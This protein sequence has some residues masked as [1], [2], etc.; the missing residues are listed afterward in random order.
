[1]TF[2]GSLDV[3]DALAAYFPYAFPMYF[4][5][6]VIAK[7]LRVAFA[8][9]DKPLVSERLQFCHNIFLA[10]QSFLLMGVIALLYPDTAQN[11]GE[12][13]LYNA[14][15][16]MSNLKARV[17]SQYFDFAI[18]TFLLSKLYEILDTV[19]LILN[20]K[21]LLLLHVWHHATT[22]LAFYTGLFTA[23]GF[24]IGFLNSF[25]HVIMYLYYAKVPGIK[26]FAKYITSLQIFHLLGGT[27]LNLY[28]LWI[29]PSSVVHHSVSV[30]I[31]QCAA[32]NAF[33]CFSY[34]FLFL[35]FFSKKYH[36]NG[37]IWSLFGFPAAAQRHV[38]TAQ[39]AICLGS[40]T[41]EQYMIAQ[42]LFVPSAEPKKA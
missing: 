2:L 29:A 28:T 15:S 32:F 19:I 11:S 5:I 26:P 14:V 7:L 33:L 38:R 42:G 1:M 34:F 25:I 16:V 12:H 40:A 21:P 20:G 24:W 39:R 22:Y 3:T 10:V 36:K 9:D 30:P 13:P 41:V 23:A 27:M 17:D 18:N 4:A 8:R 31:T 35:A 37:S 6:L